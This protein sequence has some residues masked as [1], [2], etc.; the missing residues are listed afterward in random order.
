MTA[1][2]APDG[3]VP[4]NAVLS[5]APDASSA[6]R[7]DSRRT[8]DRALLGGLA[9]TAGGRWFSQL[10]RWAATLITARLLLPEDYGIVGMATVVTGLLQNVAEFGFGAAI[11]Q[12]RDLSDAEVRQIGGASL[13]ISAALILVVVALTPLAVLYFTEPALAWVLPVLSL[14]FLIDSMAMVPRSVLARDLAFR[15]LSVFEGIESVTMAV[16]T[17]ALAWLTRSYW[18]LV[19]GVM[20]GGLVFAL[21]AYRAVPLTPRRPRSLDTVLPHVRFG[22]NVVV[23]RVAWYSYTNVD[24]AIVGRLMSERV[25]GLYNMAW[26]VASL[27]AEKLAGLVLRVAPSVLAAARQHPGEMRRYYLLLVRGVAL[28]TFP[29]A[30]GLSLV[31]GPVVRSVLGDQWLGA[32]DALRF[33][34]LLFAVRSV[35][36]LAPVVM[37]AHGKPDVDRNYSLIYLCLLPPCFLVGSRWGIA[38]IAATWMVAYPVLFGLLGQRWVL[39]SLEIRAGEFVRELWPALSS[40]I[41]M[42]AAVLGIERALIESPAV[43]KLLAMTGTGALTYVLALRTLHRSSYGSA[44]GLLRNRGFRE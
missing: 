36:S 42:S 30:V 34:A 37:I 38:G 19:A 24:F 21:L 25:F 16:A 23:A 7:A 10:F 17:V 11:V 41:L 43:A 13:L 2:T 1:K 12:R 26:N 8:L 33:L 39:R 40:T 32:I 27:P 31:S 20:T 3:S 15:K 28:V 5:N 22:G 14:R 4:S 29:I 44:V 9:W 18:S 35:A 6:G